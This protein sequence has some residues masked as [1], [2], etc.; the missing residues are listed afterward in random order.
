MERCDEARPRARRGRPR[1]GLGGDRRPG[2]RC[3]RDHHRPRGVGGR[4]RIAPPRRRSAP[5]RRHT[6]PLHHHRDGRRRGGRRDRR[7]GRGRAGRADHRPRPRRLQQ[8]GRR[9][10]RRG[11]Q[12]DRRV[13]HRCAGGR[14]D[15]PG[16]LRRL[17]P[18]DH[19]ADDRPPVDRRRARQASSSSPA[20]S[21]TTRSPQARSWPARREHVPSWS[22]PTAQTRAACPPS[23]SSRPRPATNGV[24]VDVVALGQSPEQQATLE[25]LASAAGGQV[26]PAEPTALGA[27]FSAQAEALASQVLVTFD[28]PDGISGDQIDRGVAVGGRVDLHRLRPRVPGGRDPRPTLLEVVTSPTS[29]S[30]EEVLS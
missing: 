11:H 17:R 21:S 9:Q 24:V 22:S 8:H 15:R 19:R 5:G 23:T 25:G 10:D 20:P 14:P 16:H 4:H 1:P 28:L 7:D 26:I 6:G 18:A 2:L 13:P 3:R 27:V 29:P 12:R 30:S